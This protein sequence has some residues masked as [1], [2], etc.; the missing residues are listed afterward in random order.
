[1]SHPVRAWLE[2]Q[3]LHVKGEFTVPWG[4]CD[5]VALRF[6]PA[7]V[8]Q[9]LRLGQRRPIGSLLRV[10]ILDRI[11]D[12]ESERSVTIRR[13][14][15]DFAGLLDA[16][17]LASELERLVA[18]RFVRFSRR[19]SVQK[20]NGWAPLHSRMIAIE[21]KLGRVQEALAQARSHLRFADQ[22]FVAFPEPVARRVVATRAEL[23]RS[24][25]VGVIAVRRDGCVIALRPYRR[26]RPEADEVLQAHCVERFWRTM[27]RGT[28]A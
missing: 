1:M 25:N 13:L 6:R 24:A 2:S 7:K 5:F 9:R 14:E 12:V 22:S 17:R 28:G 10:S 11:P 26:D 20:V 4:I 16:R 27:P 21:L 3:R 8:R 15:R 23:F 18:D 19:G